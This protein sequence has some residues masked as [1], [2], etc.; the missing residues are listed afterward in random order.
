MIIYPIHKQL[1]SIG[2]H[3]HFTILLCTNYL[4][5]R[6]KRQREREK[7]LQRGR[8]WERK[9]LKC[10]YYSNAISDVINSSSVTNAPVAKT[11]I[12]IPLNTRFFMQIS[13]PRHYCYVMVNKKAQLP[14]E[15]YWVRPERG[16]CHHKEGWQVVMVLAPLAGRSGYAP[17]Q[18]LWVIHLD[19]CCGHVNF[20]RLFSLLLWSLLT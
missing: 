13:K 12:I 9:E 19:K 7:K 8:E 10:R 18:K 5:Q 4:A 3:E 6:R 2:S 15:L 16:E 14:W 20:L 11:D 17:W 1:P